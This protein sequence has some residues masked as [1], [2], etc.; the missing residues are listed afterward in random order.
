[1][2]ILYQS[3]DGNNVTVSP[4]TA[5]GHNMPQYDSS[6]QITLLEGSGVSGSQMVANIKCSSCGANADV[7][8]SSASW[9][10]ATKSGSPIQSD[11]QSESISQNGNDYGSFSWDYSN[12][13]GGSSVNPF[14][15]SNAVSSGGA[16]TGAASTCTPAPSQTLA[17]LTGSDCPTAYPTEFSTSWPTARPTWAAS[18]FPSGGPGGSGGPWP[19]DAPW[20]TN[21]K[22]DNECTTDGISNSNS[23]ASGTSSGSSL[24]NNGRNGGS[25]GSRQT[26]LLAHAVMASLAFL[27]LFPVGGI[28]IRVASFT[29]LIWVHAALQILAYIVYIIAFGMGIWIA[30]N[31]NYITEAHPIIGIVLFIIILMQP[32]SGWLHHRNFK[33]YGGR[34]TSSY[35][36]I[37]I[38]RIAIILGMING[39]LGLKL[40]G[41]TNTG[42][43][44]GYAVVAGVFGLA[45]ILA[46][47]YGE[48]KRKRDSGDHIGRRRGRHPPSYRH[49][50]KDYRMSEYGSSEGDSPVGEGREFYAKRTRSSH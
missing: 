42:H 16:A 30:V 46:I 34:T 27:V 48:R 29:G 40:A 10:H 21:N 36:H 41:N 18:C 44:V 45:Y 47:I 37:G 39:G 35:A 6:T 5:S 17:S 2:F 24:S 20:R 13:K 9:I 8:E 32:L 1:M 23:G 7:S 11:D 3:A 49:S 25:M 38:G 26:I 50:Q 14:A 22:R 31:G 28:L 43:V 12:A 15:S 33:K 19:T 4:R